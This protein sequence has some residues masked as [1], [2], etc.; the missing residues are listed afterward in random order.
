M[1]DRNYTL[2]IVSVD[3]RAQRAVIGNDRI[4][5]QHAS[6]F[7][8]SVFAGLGHLP[9]EIGKLRKKLFIDI[10]KRD[11]ITPKQ[12]Q[13]TDGIQHRSRIVPAPPLG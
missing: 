3:R 9:Q 5:P 11:I 13:R 4:I 7:P 8:H 12:L 1:V 6:G 2:F 10:A